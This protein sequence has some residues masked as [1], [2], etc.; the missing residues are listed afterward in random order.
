M[1][2]PIEASRRPNGWL[3]TAVC[4]LL[5]QSRRPLTGHDIADRLNRRHGAIHRS[6]VFRALERLVAT[7]RVRRIEL[8][9]AYRLARGKPGIDLVCRQCG[10]TAVIEQE[11][12]EPMLADLARAGGMEPTRFIV[13]VSGFC[14]ICA[15]SGRHD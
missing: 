7:G 12:V 6:A 14:P 15:G 2:T 11:M 8:T 5:G 1:P 13:E 3:H 9:K 10:S 4:R